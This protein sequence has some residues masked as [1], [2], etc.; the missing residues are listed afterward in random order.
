MT[1][2]FNFFSCFCFFPTGAPEKSDPLK[3]QH[4][5]LRRVDELRRASGV[6]ASFLGVFFPSLNSSGK[7]KCSFMSDQR[8]LLHSVCFFLKVPWQVVSVSGIT[9]HFNI[10]KS[11]IPSV[12]FTGSCKTN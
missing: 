2:V 5:H 12:E 10:W 1:R 8:L 4:F 7:G 11:K 6:P 3:L 9:T